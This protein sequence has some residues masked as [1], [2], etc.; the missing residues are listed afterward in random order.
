[1]IKEKLITYQKK[2]G[3]PFLELFNEFHC[4]HVAIDMAN[5]YEIDFLIASRRQIDDE[6]FGGGYVNNWTT[7]NFIIRN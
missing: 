3:V 6:L 1:M 4:V 2:Q 5:R 7:E